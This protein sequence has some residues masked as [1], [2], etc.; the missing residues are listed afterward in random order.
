MGAVVRALSKM[1]PAAKWI[2]A[3]SGF[4]ETKEEPI[5]QGRGAVAGPETA[6]L[7][8][9]GHSRCLRCRHKRHW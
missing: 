4:W 6:E 2:L 5:F 7:E 9:R 8:G 3:W 1:S